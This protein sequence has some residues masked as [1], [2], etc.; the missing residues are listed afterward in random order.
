MFVTSTSSNCHLPSLLSEKELDSIRGKTRSFN[1]LMKHPRASLPDI[2]DL[3]DNLGVYLEVLL[4]N[5][6]KTRGNIEK[7]DVINKARHLLED[8][9]IRVILKGETL[10]DA[11]KTVSG[12][13]S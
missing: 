7:M 1:K 3:I 9:L 11:T 12:F 6:P 5:A 4:V 8:I 10:E 13:Y 2:Q